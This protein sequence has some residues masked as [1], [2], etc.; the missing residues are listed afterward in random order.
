MT[1]KNPKGARQVVNAR[2]QSYIAAVR[3]QLPTSSI[4][5]WERIEPPVPG[6]EKRRNPAT[7][8]EA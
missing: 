3:Q 5:F 8:R 6:T 4:Q 2:L 7:G 1:I